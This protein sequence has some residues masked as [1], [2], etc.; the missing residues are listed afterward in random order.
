MAGWADAA[1]EIAAFDPNS[2]QEKLIAE[3]TAMGT[4]AFNHIQQLREQ[5]P[6]TSVMSQV[7]HATIPGDDGRPR[8]LDDL[9][10]IRF[11]NLL[12]T[13]GS[14]TTR[15][16]ITGGYYQLLKNPVQLQTLE[17]KTDQ[18]ID[19]GDADKPNRFRHA[20]RETL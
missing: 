9:E 1:I 7:V 5:E 3:L 11:F 17:A 19:G 12:I 16:A 4:Y 18:L 8:A 20:S 13:G 15:N 10:L 14:E 2:D 6:D